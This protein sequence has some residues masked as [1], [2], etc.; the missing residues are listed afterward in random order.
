MNDQDKILDCIEVEKNNIR[1]NED[2]RKSK[3][4]DADLIETVQLLKDF[5]INI[6]ISKIPDFSSM[7]ELERWRLK[8]IKERLEPH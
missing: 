1:R 8:K 2:K 3:P 4:T 7:S 5:G 6:K